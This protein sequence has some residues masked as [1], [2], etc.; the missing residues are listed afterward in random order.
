M[1]D[2]ELYLYPFPKFLWIL[3]GAFYIGGAIIYG[4]RLPERLFPKRMDYFG[5]S[6]NI[7]HFCV[8]IAAVIHFYGS[9]DNYNG[10]MVLV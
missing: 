7:F 10:R 6:H 8:L 9:M 5:S 3:G 2:D 1:I 4:I